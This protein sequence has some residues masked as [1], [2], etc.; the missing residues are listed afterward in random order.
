MKTENIKKEE[1]IN[2]L[3]KNGYSNE[4]YKLLM[5]ISDFSKEQATTAVDFS[6]EDTKLISSARSHLSFVTKFGEKESHIVEG[7]KHYFS[8]PE[9]FDE[10]IKA[11]SP[12][13]L[14]EELELCLNSLM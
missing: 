13:V 14:L 8:Y 4:L 7:E 10:W 12:G 2:L 6:L 11:G 1:L 5:G 9:K 3:M